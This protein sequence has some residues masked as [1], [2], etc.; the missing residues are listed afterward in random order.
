MKKTNKKIFGGLLVA[1]FIATIGAVIANA[2]PGFFSEITEEQ[3]AELWEMRESLIED[4]ASCQ[5]TRDAMREQLES[6]GVELPT[7]D[8]MLAKKIEFT[9]QRLD[10]LERKHELRDE[11]FE[12]EEIRE[13]IEE[14]FDLEF[15]DDAGCGKGFRRGFRQGYRRCLCNSGSEE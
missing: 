10:I 5:E 8:E 13:I 3:K 2:Q 9:Q 7:R 12:W 1:M 15:P 11:G 6:Y 14:E 4:G